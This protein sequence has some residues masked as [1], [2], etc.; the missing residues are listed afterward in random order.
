MTTSQPRFRLPGDPLSVL[1]PDLANTRTRLDLMWHDGRLGIRGPSGDGG[2]FAFTSIEDPDAA[3]E[4]KDMCRAF[5]AD[6]PP[7]AQAQVRF[8]C[9]EAETASI[10][11][12]PPESPV[13]PTRA[14]RRLGLWL[15]ASRA[16]IDRLVR[17]RRWLER[18]LS[19]GWT[20]E[21]GQ[22][23][24]AAVAGPGGPVTA[25]AVPY[26][27]LPS[28]D[29]AGAAIPLASTIASF[30]QPGPEANRALIACA[31]ELLDHA[32][33]ATAS[34]FEWG[35]GYGNLSAAMAS[36]LGGGGEATE[37]HPAAAALLEANGRR[38]FPEVRT[39]PRSAE[40]EDNNNVDAQLWIID[41]PRPGFGRL[42]ESLARRAHRPERILAFH[43]HETGLRN[44]ARILFESGAAPEAWSSVDLFP[45]S[46]HLEVVSLWKVP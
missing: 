19:R 28:F 13:P 31:F 42:L 23:G 41:P 9:A 32:G 22:R 45:G 12:A 37:S 36:R 43:C 34:W 35:A 14:P 29:T 7:V 46:P 30:S 16:D 18:A 24:E 21:L 20:V 27:W 2:T 26:A 1:T 33:V 3:P 44:D 25:P 11:Q 10:G 4:L 39:L 40:S 8:R 38:F 5:A 15:D 17:E 6:P